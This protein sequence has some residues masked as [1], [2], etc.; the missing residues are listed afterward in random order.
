MAKPSSKRFVS[1]LLSMF[2][3]LAAIVGYS[4]FVVPALQEAKLL[5][6]EMDAKEQFYDDQR[7]AIE[8]IKAW[9]SQFEENAQLQ[10]AM[11]SILPVGDS[12]QSLL[13]AQV[14]GLAALNGLVLDNLSMRVGPIEPPSFE[15]PLAAGM[16]K[17]TLEFSAAGSY[18]ALKNFL[19][20]LETNIRIM[21]V[22]SL[23]AEAI[24]GQNLFRLDF[25]VDVYYQAKSTQ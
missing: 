19:S 18:E 9:L 13:V 5:R 7:L 15:I 3:I 24:A 20:A 21:D 8:R 2:F 16:G 12:R 25:A 4:L 23:D 1:I 6:G 10:E 22:A 17:V 11:N 14:S